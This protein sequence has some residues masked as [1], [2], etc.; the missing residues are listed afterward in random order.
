MWDVSSDC[1][2]SMIYTTNWIE[3]IQNG[4]RRVTRMRGAMPGEES[5][6]LLAGKATMD[7][8]FYRRQVT[9][10]DLDRGLFP[11]DHLRTH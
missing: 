2:Q 1:I 11:Y 4:F 7:M 5:V 8:K 10:I 9:G 6:L 3:R